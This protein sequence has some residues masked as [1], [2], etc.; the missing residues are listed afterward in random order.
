MVAHVEL[1]EVDVLV[2]PP[3]TTATNEVVV[4]QT[5]AVFV[6]QALSGFDL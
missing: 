5:D 6:S 2:A 4:E 1:A 3:D